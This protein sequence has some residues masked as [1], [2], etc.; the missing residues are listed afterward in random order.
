MFD[1]QFL[2]QAAYMKQRLGDV[3]VAARY[4]AEASSINF[5]RSCVYGLEAL[6]C[7]GQFVLQRLGLARFDLFVPKPPK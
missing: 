1:Q 5:R 3:P 6:W 4:F 2:I 7:L